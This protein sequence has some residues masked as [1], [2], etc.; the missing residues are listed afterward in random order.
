MV[1]AAAAPDVPRLVKPPL[2]H[3]LAPG[4]GEVSAA[5]REALFRRGPLPEGAGGEGEVGG[6]MR[7][8]QQEQP[9]QQYLPA[10]LLQRLREQQQDPQPPP[11]SASEGLEPWE[12]WWGLH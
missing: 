6:G 7:R 1:L 2:P 9:A 3:G 10:Q 8:R 12:P 11:A 4:E 5:A